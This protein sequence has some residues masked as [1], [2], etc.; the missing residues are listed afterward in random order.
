MEAHGTVSRGYVWVVQP[1]DPNTNLGDCSM[2][3]SRFTE[4]QVADAFPEYN[5]ST[6]LGAGG[7][8]CVYLGN[9]GQEAVALKI[10]LQGQDLIRAERECEKLKQINCPTVL[11][12]IDYGTREVEGIDTFYGV[13][14]YQPGDDLRKKL[15]SD[16]KLPPDEVVRLVTDIA[17]AVDALWAARV[18]HCDL[19]P[20]NILI[21]QSGSY[22]VADLGY[23]RHHDLATITPAGIGFGTPGYMA[24]ELWHRRS[25]TPRADLFALGVVA[26]E[27]LT[28]RHP[29]GG[30]GL[31]SQ[32]AILS[33]ARPPDPQKFVSQAPKGLLAAID[34]MLRVNVLLRPATGAQVIKIVGG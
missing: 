10:Y 28:G 6:V 12:M 5:I 18:V 3:S 27:A 15:A 1:L 31:H 7:Q 30:P 34:R 19:K 24:P 13:T 21:S 23:A 16:G 14:S 22:I 17:S 20:A 25:L 29:F 11:K 26:Y 33:G 8:A 9:D 2:S 4:K 32:K